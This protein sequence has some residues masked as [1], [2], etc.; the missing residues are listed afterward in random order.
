MGGLGD[1]RWNK[2]RE[3]QLASVY[4]EVVAAAG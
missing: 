3:A 4:R 1:T 2:R